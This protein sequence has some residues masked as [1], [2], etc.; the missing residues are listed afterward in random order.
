MALMAGRDAGEK[1]QKPFSGRQWENILV[2]VSR[3]EK[4]LMKLEEFY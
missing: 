4:M 2:K 1:R 3:S